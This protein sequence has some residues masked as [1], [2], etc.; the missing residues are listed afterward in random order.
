MSDF[1]AARRL[2]AIPGVGAQVVAWM[3]PVAR[4][5]RSGIRDSDY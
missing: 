2:I 5:K 1:F 4:M 3:K